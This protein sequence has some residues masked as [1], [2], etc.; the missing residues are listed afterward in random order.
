MVNAPTFSVTGKPAFTDNFIS[1]PVAGKP[2]TLVI[3]TVICSALVNS[4]ASVGE[5]NE[6]TEISLVATAPNSSAPISGCV[7][8][9]ASP[10]KSVVT[11]A[12][13]TA[14][15]SKAFCETCKSVAEVKFGSI[16]KE[17]ASWLLATCQAAKSVTVVPFQY[18]KF[19]PTANKS[20]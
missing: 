11:E 14:A 3:L 19:A 5:I 18:A 1:N 7:A 10:S 20:L 4:Q 15:L 16:D 8:L 13:M 9:L 12:M 17:F 2:P 6:V